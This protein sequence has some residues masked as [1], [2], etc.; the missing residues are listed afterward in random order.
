M[1]WF[2]L[3]FLGGCTGASIFLLLE[4]IVRI[5]FSVPMEPGVKLTLRNEIPGISS[6]VRYSFDGYRLR[7]TNWLDDNRDDSV[8]VICFG[9]NATTT[10]FQTAEDAWWGKLGERFLVCQGSFSN[11]L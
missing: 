5:F 2:K 11:G 9:G 4:I 7:K 3:V 10:V 6:N 8:R 1:K